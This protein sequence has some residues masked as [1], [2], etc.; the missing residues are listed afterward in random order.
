MRSNAWSFC[1]SVSCSR[2]RIISFIIF[3]QVPQV[4]GFDPVLL[5]GSAADAIPFMKSATWRQVAPNVVAGNAENLSF[6]PLTPSSWLGSKTWRQ[7]VTDVTAEDVESLSANHLTLSAWIGWI[8]FLMWL[9]L[10][11]PLPKVD[12]QPLAPPVP[13]ESDISVEVPG[14][15]GCARTKQTCRQAP[16]GRSNYP[17]AA[18]PRRVTTND[19]VFKHQNHKRKKGK[20]GEKGKNETSPVKKKKGLLEG[21]EKAEKMKALGEEMKAAGVSL[22]WLRGF[23]R[24]LEKDQQDTLK[25]ALVRLGNRLWRLNN[26]MKALPVPTTG[27]E[28]NQ[29][30]EELDPYLGPYVYGLLQRFTKRLQEPGNEDLRKTWEK[31]L[32]YLLKVIFAEYGWPYSLVDEWIPILEEFFDRDI[33]LDMPDSS[34]LSWSKTYCRLKAGDKAKALKE[35]ELGNADEP[36]YSFLPSNV[37][38][39]ELERF[40]TVIVDN[41]I[42]VLMAQAREGD[43]LLADSFALALYLVLDEETGLSPVQREFVHL[44]LAM[45]ELEKGYTTDWQHMF[46]HFRVKDVKEESEESMEAETEE[47]AEG[48]TASDD[49]SDVSQ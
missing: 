17:V 13:P 21:K 41:G 30:L 33:S 47:E 20:K 4:W 44:W 18:Y 37:I 39:H 40:H 11:A 36:S 26:R 5:S 38:S 45:R 9:G 15:L 3:F 14:I 27:Q 16:H 22:R 7:L 8:K 2:L 42:E 10:I 49:S 48:G 12:I 6:N 28:V 46:D 23:E 32:P 25:N 19:P 29:Q 35:V 31:A 43:L 34:Y 24:K 1:L